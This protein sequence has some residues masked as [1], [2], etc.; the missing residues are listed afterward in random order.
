MTLQGF[1]TRT[2]RYPLWTCAPT[3]RGR[4]PQ[5]SRQPLLLQHYSFLSLPGWS[6]DFQESEPSWGWRWGREA[7]LDRCPSP[8]ELFSVCFWLVFPSPGICESSV[9]IMPRKNNSQNVTRAGRAS[10]FH[11]SVHSTLPYQSGAFNRRLRHG[12]VPTRCKVDLHA[13]H[14]LIPL[15]CPVRWIWWFSRQEYTGV[16][17]S[18]LLQIPTSQRAKTK[19]WAQLSALPNVTNQM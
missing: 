14:H 9:Y 18:S 8:E 1:P 19:G 16:N 5:S 2:L 13:F 6:P 3:S 17:Y 11:G 7:S 10:S 15:K 12:W 4:A